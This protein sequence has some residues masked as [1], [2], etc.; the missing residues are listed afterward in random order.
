MTYRRKYP[1]GAELCEEGYHFR[2]WAPRCQ[3]VVAVF[4]QA[5]F[6]GEVALEKEHGYAPARPIETIICWDVLKTMRG[7][8]GAEL[9][10]RDDGTRDIVCAE[11]ERIQ[12]AEQRAAG[13]SIKDIVDRIGDHDLKHEQV[14]RGVVEAL[15]HR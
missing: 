10:T 7:H 4:D 8:H 9:Q 14:T 11:F 2:V 5:G 12:A 13:I 1:I 6:L 15:E 3:S